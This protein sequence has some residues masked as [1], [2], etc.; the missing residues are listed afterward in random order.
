MVACKGLRIA[1]TVGGLGEV[2]N[3]GDLRE[4][5]GLFGG[6]LLRTCETSQTAHDAHVCSLYAP[7]HH[8]QVA[9]LSANNRFIESKLK[10][11]ELG[12]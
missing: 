7:C 4:L 11:A 6:D 9:A 1:N 10:G 2:Q 5:W 12:R 8:P 3:D